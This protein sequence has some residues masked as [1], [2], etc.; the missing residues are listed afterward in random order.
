MG[1]DFLS[2]SAN[3]FKFLVYIRQKFVFVVFQ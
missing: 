2:A 3:L 1:A